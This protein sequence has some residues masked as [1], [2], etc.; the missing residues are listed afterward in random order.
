M[1]VAFLTMCLQKNIS[2]L[3]KQLVTLENFKLLVWKELQKP[4]ANILNT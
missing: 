3:T 4:F 1:Q 2:I